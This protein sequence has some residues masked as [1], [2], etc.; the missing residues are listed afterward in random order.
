MEIEQ[1]KYFLAVVKYK[2]FSTAAQELC[3]S[4][5]SL[6]KRLKALEDELGT[7]LINRATKTVTLTGE[8]LVNFSE[9]VIARYDDLK[10]KIKKHSNLEEGHINLGMSQIVN[11]QGLIG[12]IASFQKEHPGIKINLVEKK[13]KDLI[14]LLRDNKIDAAF[15]LTNLDEDTGLKIQPLIND[16]YVLVTDMK[17]PLAKNKFIDLSEIANEKFILLDPSTGMH[18]TPVGAC[19]KAG[20]TPSILYESDQIDTILDLVSE[21]LGVSLLMHDSVNYYGH[22]GVKIVKLN[23]PISGITALAL[24]RNKN[25]N[26]S[27]SAFQKYI[28][29]SLI[30]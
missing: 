18:D 3:I 9:E 28:L 1:L 11:C 15:I 7:E 29:S 10:L 25:L 6:S 20:F 14:K 24:P 23:E 13:T 4:Q 2:N 16:E 27:I 8:E 26:N 17:H 30:L 12:L 21:G 22:L 5:S 19:K